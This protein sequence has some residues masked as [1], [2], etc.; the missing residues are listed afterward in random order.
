MA[1]KAITILR[2]TLIRISVVLIKLKLFL[3]EQVV[4]IFFSTFHHHQ[5]LPHIETMAP[6]TVPTRI[7]MMSDTHEYEFDGSNTPEVDVLL[8]CGDMTHVGGT[9]AYKRSLRM[10]RTIKASCFRIGL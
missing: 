5:S 10:M 7:M 6:S 8:H 4:K 9:G 1:F 2:A 3:P